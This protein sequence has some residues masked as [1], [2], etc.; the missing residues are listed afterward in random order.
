MHAEFLDIM[1][2]EGTNEIFFVEFVDK[3]N[4]SFFLENCQI[5]D[6]GV[7][8]WRWTKYPRKAVWFFYE[9]QTGPFADT[10]ANR[11]DVK[12]VHMHKRK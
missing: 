1:K 12:I 4:K 8:V 10:F 3:N 2:E 6:K 5:D 9:D 11:E 7:T